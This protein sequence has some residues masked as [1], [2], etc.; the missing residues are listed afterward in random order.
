MSSTPQRILTAI[1]AVILLG[2]V[3]YFWNTQG[4]VFLSIAIAFKMQYEYA[5][6]MLVKSVGWRVSST[7]IFGTFVCLLVALFSPLYF[8]PVF[9]FVAL[10]LISLFMFGIG[11]GDDLKDIFFHQSLIALG[12]IYCGI[13]PYMIIR[14]LMFER[15][16]A[17]FATLFVVV[18]AGDIGAYFVGR[19]IGGPKIAPVISPHKTWSGAYGG[20]CAS[21]LSGGLLCYYLFPQVP[22]V[23]FVLFSVLMGGF[24]QIGDFFE[25]LMKRVA[26][27]KDS[28]TIMP[29][30]GG[31]LDRLDGILFAV[32]MIFLLALRYNPIVF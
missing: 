18:F 17:W 3:F 4:L 22:I 16:L 5:R 29:G 13:L 23:F 10:L 9:S 19:K 1:V 21:A 24:A 14:L 31:L 20:L 8:I 25:S 28:G 26:G 15:G 11:E 30:H 32:P 2:T 7:F 6:M 12:I 27:V